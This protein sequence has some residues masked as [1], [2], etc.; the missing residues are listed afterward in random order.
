MRR[1]SL[2]VTPEPLEVWIGGTAEPAIDRAARLGDGWLANADGVPDAARGA[3]RDLPRAV[4]GVRSHAHRRRDSARHPCGRQRR[5]RRASRGADRVRRLPGIPSGRVRVR[6]R[7]TG[8]RSLPC[9]GR[10]G[11]HRC[12]R[13]PAR[14]RASRCGRI[15]RTARRRP[16]RWS[17]MRDRLPCFGLVVQSSWRKTLPSALR[18]NSST[19]RTARGRL[20]GCELARPRTRAGRPA[21]TG[22]R[23]RPP[24]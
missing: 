20:Y 14:L 2:P 1:A 10:H 8:R 22:R 6:E 24:R 13:A 21:S 12:H 4:R 17:P 3:G 7:R 16:R 9:A 23:R 11:L 5:G 18:G 15:D 19:K